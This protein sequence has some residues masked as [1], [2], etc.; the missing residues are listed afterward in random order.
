M[1]KINLPSKDLVLNSL[2]NKGMN[3][4]MENL[5]MMDVLKC[6]LGMRKNLDEKLKFLIDEKLENNNNLKEKEKFF[7]N[8]PDYFNNLETNSLKAQSFLNLNITD[9]N[10]NISLS[11]RLPHPLFVLY[12]CFECID[13]KKIEYEVKI[14]GKPEKIDEFYEN[15]NLENIKFD[16]EKSDDN[17]D[18]KEEGEHSDDGEIN[19]EEIKTNEKCLY[20]LKMIK[21]KNEKIKI[22]KNSSIENISKIKKFPLYVQLLIARIKNEKSNIGITKDLPIFINFYYLPIFN[23]VSTELIINS[24]NSIFNTNSLLSNIFMA[25][26]NLLSNTKK[27]INMAIGN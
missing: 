12:N 22:R 25:P 7:K 1:D 20:K 10:E 15:Y 9:K 18:N 3:I 4:D 21:R 24:K 16:E 5:K 2:S 23:I 17:N 27:E 13:K 26:S 11:E 14:L 6:E 19:E 8:L